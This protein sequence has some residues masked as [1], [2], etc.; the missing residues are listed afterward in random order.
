MLTSGPNSDSILYWGVRRTELGQ[1]DIRI[2]Y[3]PEVFM[4]LPEIKSKE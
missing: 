3:D 2:V 1:Q 4:D